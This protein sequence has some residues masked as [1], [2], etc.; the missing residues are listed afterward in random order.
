MCQPGR[1]RNR[2]ANARIA[3]RA[4]GCSRRRHRVQ[5][6]PA[7]EAG[8]DQSG[9]ENTERDSS[10]WI[11]T[12]EK[13]A[14]G[15]EAFCDQCGDAHGAS[16]LTVCC[17]PRCGVSFSQCPKCGVEYAGCCSAACQAL[18]T[19]RATAFEIDEVVAGSRDSGAA[20]AHI[21]RRRRPSSSREAPN[22]VLSSGFI[23]VNGKPRGG[24]AGDAKVPDARAAEHV[25]MATSSHQ[26]N[27]GSSGDDFRENST[28][29]RGSPGS[30]AAAAAAAGGS[31]SLTG[32]KDEEDLVESYASRHS[33]QESSPLTEI[34]EATTR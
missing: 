27:V 12:V 18:A 9:V 33:A 7:A 31:N 17:S 16:E 5:C 23:A 6:L 20:S 29:V 10:F 13:E 24:I 11:E 25:G 32:M 2:A 14:L 30:D 3:S 19:P 4:T 22:V 8:A 34:R 28:S 21:K 26:A 15:G 1:Q